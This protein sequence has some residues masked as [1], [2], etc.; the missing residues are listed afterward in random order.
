[1]MA[2]GTKIKISIDSNDLGH[3]FGELEQGDC[4]IRDG[5]LEMKIALTGGFNALVLHSELYNKCGDTLY[6]A[7]E[8]RV[9]P[10]EAELRV[11]KPAAAPEPA[12]PLTFGDLKVGEWFRFVGDGSHDGTGPDE[13]L[14]LGPTF[15]KVKKQ[16]DSYNGSCAR[17][18][19]GTLYGSEDHWLVERL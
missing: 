4:F 16:T 12:K 19:T 6:H 14:M 18:N 11:G 10:V 8:D 9:W 1:M 7:D 2:M 15:L 13:P 3:R 17:A 5:R